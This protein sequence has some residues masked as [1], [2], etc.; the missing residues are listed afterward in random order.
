[1]AI[2]TLNRTEPSTA[3]EYTGSPVAALE[4]LHERHQIV[5]ALFRKRVVERGADAANGSVSLKTVQSRVSGF[6]YEEL[7]ERFAGKPKRH[8]HQ[9]SIVFPR[10]A[11]VEPAPIDLGVK[12]A[13]LALVPLAD[14]REATLGAQ[15]LHHKT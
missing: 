1:M 8:V 4:F 5:H 7:L 11:A 14:D 13:G 10:R 9:G 15:P 6:L 12:L 3:K 2:T